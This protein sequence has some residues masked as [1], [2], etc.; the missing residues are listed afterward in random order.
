MILGRTSISSAVVSV[1]AILWAL[2]VHS[3]PDTPREVA[4]SLV[5]ASGVTGGVIVHVGC[6]DGRLTAALRVNDSFLVHG[7]DADPD[8]VRKARA[9]IRELGVYGQ[10]SVVE[11]DGERLPYTENLVN[12]VVAG[13]EC[14]VSRDEII[15]VLA[16]GGAAVFLDAQDAVRDTLRKAVPAN[17]DEWTHFLHG[18]DNNAVCHDTAVGI[19]R[20]IQWV[21]GPRWGRSHEELA[22]MSAAV[23]ASG[24]IFYILDEAPLASIRFSG[25][26]TLIARD[27]FNGILLWK[28][29]IS[30][31]ND[32]L[33]HFR[34]GPVHLP[35]RLVSIGDTVFVTLGFTE[36][37]LAL[38]A[39][40]GE[41]LREYAG[42]E[43]TEE[44]L[45]H[46][47]VLYLVVGTSEAK[48]RGGGLYG[49]GEPD[50][51]AFRQL[52]AV[53]IESG[54]PN[55]SKDLTNEGILPLSLAVKGKR[56]YFQSL[57]GVVCLD[58]GS[59]AECW[60]TPRSTPA[61]R[62]SFSAPTLV[63]TDDV[64]LCADKDTSDSEENR[65]STGAIEWAVH[66]WTEKGFARGGTSTLRAYSATDGKELW[67]AKCR[68]GYNSPVDVFVVQGVVWVGRDFRG[69]DLK[70]GKQV[71][72]INTKA[73]RVGMPHHRCYRN[74]ASERFI[75]AGKSGIE[76]L[77]FTQ[78]WLSNNSWLRGTCQYGIIPAN[79]LLYAPP[80]ACACFLTVK[81]PGF[82][83]AAPQRGQT[84]HMPFPD[85]PV[86]RKGPAYAS[87]GTRAPN[88]EAN[89]WPMYRHDPARSGAVSGPLPD[90]PARR[91][92]TAI[93]AR[94]TQPAIAGGKV[95]VASTETHTVH[96]LSTAD[97]REA[98][99]YTAGGRIDSTPTIYRNTVIFGSADGWVTCVRAH[100]GV[101]AWRFRVAPE[102]RL[103]GAHGQLEST[104]PAHGAVL[105]QNDRLYVTA[106]RSTYLD[107][108]LVLYCIEPGTGEQLS[109][110]VLYHLDP[111]SGQQLVPEA[112]F[113]MEGTTSDVLSGNGDLVF[114]KYFTFARTGKRTEAAIPRLFSITG[115]LGE[116]WFVRSY[117]IIG[118]QLGAGWSGWANAANQY[119]SG[120]LLCFTGDKV[121]GY[122]RRQVS[123]GAVGHRADA[124][125]LFGA[126]IKAQSQQT[127]RKGK[128]RS[129]K[130]AAIWTD[131]DSLIVR[132]MVLGSERLAVAGPV[133]TGQRAA[134]LLAFTNEDD[135]LAGF[136]GGKGVLLRIVRST[137][138]KRI[139]ES[140][141]DA[142]PVFDGM[143]AADGHLYLALKNGELLCFKPGEGT[144]LPDPPPAPP[145]QPA[146][147]Q[148]VGRQTPP[149]PPAQLAGTDK[150][151]D[152]SHVSAAG[153]VASDL[154]YRL[155]SGKGQVGLALKKLDVPLQKRAVFKASLRRAPEY[156][157]PHLFENA[158]LAFGDG[159]EDT[160]LV[161]CGIKFVVTSAVILSGPTK[162]QAAQ[163]QK[164]ALDKSKPVE[165]TVTVD[166]ASGKV[167]LTATGQTIEAKLQRPLTSITHVGY[168]T[169]N[170]CSDF[171]PI[172]ISGE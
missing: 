38:S 54:K 169:L 94:L 85:V 108:G 2:P 21:S 109:R 172:D 44:I 151:G 37:V 105:I 136:T 141:L 122:G 113:N 160:D 114:L 1:I 135:A 73:P 18:P 78:G 20:S 51:T 6:G 36:P 100:D 17:I 99:R 59:G 127:D 68:E 27:A 143:A 155:A 149:K 65:P 52:M 98:W 23:T 88:P 166:L 111:G 104:W 70:T 12:L 103:V 3:A 152:F 74:K 163:S 144:P 5:T 162:G 123:G 10:V 31:W 129:S 16:P 14:R 56:L 134:D 110:N 142:V 83:A 81:A 153:I 119:P 57:L 71:G 131:T 19:P 107:G 39:A 80:D 67:S 170:A 25:D 62:M 161:K 116:E 69:F 46:N 13:V 124:Y 7:L 158:F 8:N 55:W 58:A 49:R 28:R 148:T 32:H 76:V 87:L 9:T 53:E 89:D 34:S 24:R 33:R 29:A 147:A 165:V 159:A 120:R 63:A 66:G 102:D 139:S 4:A 22:S 101:L 11:L 137:D 146:P 79:G 26:W 41:T 145:E 15:R 171:S 97:G 47:G 61:R 82:F 140:K 117:W 168:C 92:A 128:K 106:G 125:H 126:D 121:Y 42:T 95:V 60:Q 35:R 91:W 45:A 164:I 72:K 138:G 133:D 43:R 115:F 64:I 132:A 50:P 77:S 112:G 167:A 40:T 93:G 118:L 157:Y 150:S 90:F 75:F 30:G 84:G 86:L 156:L 48:R 130:P 96:A 154:G